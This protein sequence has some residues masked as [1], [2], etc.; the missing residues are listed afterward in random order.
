MAFAEVEFGVR[1]GILHFFH[2]MIILSLFRD[3]LARGYQR[4]RHY[5]LVSCNYF[6]CV[7]VNTKNK[8]ANMKAFIT[9]RYTGSY[10]KMRGLSNH[11]YLIAI[12]VSYYSYKVACQ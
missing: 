9:G 10:L 2:Y 7:P 8:T 6:I 12:S 11:V 4:C 3:F 1:L 5:R